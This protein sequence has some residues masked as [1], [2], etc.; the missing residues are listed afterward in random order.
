MKWDGLDL[1]QCY[2]KADRSLPGGV[3]M[4]PGLYSFTG[5]LLQIGHDDNE[6]GRKAPV[7]QKQVERVKRRITRSAAVRYG[8]HGLRMRLLVTDR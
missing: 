1:R 4:S 7:S 8:K 6:G 5:S 3:E 2:T